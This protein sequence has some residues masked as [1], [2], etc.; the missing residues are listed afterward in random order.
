MDWLRFLY[1]K[2]H[3]TLQWF[4]VSLNLYDAGW[5][6]LVLKNDARPFEG[7]GYLRVERFV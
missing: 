7:S 5:G 3:W 1:P 6:V 4:R 2:D